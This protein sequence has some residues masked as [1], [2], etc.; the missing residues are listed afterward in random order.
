MEAVCPPLVSVYIPLG[1]ESDEFP[2]SSAM[3]FD[4]SVPAYLET[5]TAAMPGEL[6]TERIASLCREQ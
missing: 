3:F 1:D 4:A 5:E 6:V 2:P